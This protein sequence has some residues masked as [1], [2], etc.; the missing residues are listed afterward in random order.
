MGAKIYI[1]YEDHNPPHVHVVQSEHAA[2]VSIETQEVIEGRIPSSLKKLVAK[3][4]E[5]H[6][7]GLVKRWNLAKA[8]E[9]F[10]AI[11][12]ES[13]NDALHH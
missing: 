11:D 13:D 12:E 9:E 8:G 6:K 2:E 5:T 7:D 1:Y 3:W 10:E 4:I